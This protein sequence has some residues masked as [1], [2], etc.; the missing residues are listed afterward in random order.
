[1]L[2]RTSQIFLIPTPLTTHAIEMIND[3]NNRTTNFKRIYPPFP[4]K[5]QKHLPAP[6]FISSSSFLCLSF[7]SKSCP[8]LIFLTS[9]SSSSFAADLFLPV[10]LGLLLGMLVSVLL[11]ARQTLITGDAF[12]NVTSFLKTFTRK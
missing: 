11:V 10:L 7:R 1:M 8:L 3:I 6:L 2:I 5:R 9:S 12:S 4:F